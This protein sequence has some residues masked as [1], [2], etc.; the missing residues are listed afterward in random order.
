MELFITTFVVTIIMA[1]GSVLQGSVGFGIGLITVPLLALIDPLFVPGPLL[2]SALLLSFLMSSREKHASDSFEIRLALIG[3]VI[4]VI[5]AG[6]LLYFLPSQKMTILCGLLVILAVIFSYFDWNVQLT[7][8]NITGVGILSGFMSTSAA[9]GGPPVAL[10]YQNASGSR[11]RST[12]SRFFVF[13]IMLSLST[14]A[15]IGRFGL[16]EIKMTLY[17]LPGVV[18]G[19]LG[20]SRLILIVDNSN[21]TKKAVLLV[22]VVSAVVVIVRSIVFV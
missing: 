12:L 14:L 9:I 1:A 17:L 8:M 3:R 13:G 4:G 7:K 2:L 5:V 22:S 21:W 19:Y 16:Q 10:L 20:S 11:L 15:I 6:I 18:I